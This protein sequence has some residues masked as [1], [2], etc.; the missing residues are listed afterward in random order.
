MGWKAVRDFLEITQPH[1]QISMSKGN[2]QIGSGYIHDIMVFA[3]DGTLIR[4]TKGFCSGELFRIHKA[5]TES[6]EQLAELLAR[7]D[8]FSRSIPVYTYQDGEIVE[9]YCEE[10]GED[11]VTHDGQIM[12]DMSHFADKKAALA[13]AM[14]SVDS[15]IANFQASLIDLERRVVECREGI[16]RQIAEKA[17]LERLLGEFHESH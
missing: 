15:G 11:S 13:R 6:P 5:L 2:L 8:V 3:P 7:K 17:E 12:N 16:D 1:I 14:K 4:T 10:L 9:A